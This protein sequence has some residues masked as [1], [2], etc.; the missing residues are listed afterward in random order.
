MRSSGLSS[1][2]RTSGLEWHPRSKSLTDRESWHTLAQATVPTACHRIVFVARSLRSNSC[3]LLAAVNR[4]AQRV[5]PALLALS[6][7]AACAGDEPAASDGHLRAR[8]AGPRDATTLAKW[9][10]VFVD[11]PGALASVWGTSE[12]DVWLAGSDAHDGLGPLVLHLSSGK[13]LRMR[14]GATGD[15]WWVH[16]FDDGSVFFVGSEGQIHRYA[17]GRFR[18]VESPRTRGTV[19]GVWGSGPNDVWAVGGDPI[20]G[21]GAFV[22]RYAGDHFESAGTLPVAPDDVIAYFKVWGTS[23][24]DVW[25]VGTPGIVLH[26]D[27]SRLER[28]D[29]GVFEPLFTVHAAGSAYAVVGGADLGVLLEKSAGAV[30][31]RAPLPDGTGLLTGVWL[32]GASGYAVGAQGTVLTRTRAGW[33]DAKT[34]ISTT[35][36]LHSVWIDPTGDVWTVGGDVLFPPYGSGMLI[37]RGAGL[38]TTYTAEPESFDGGDGSAVATR[39]H[40]DADVDSRVDEA[41]V[42]AEAGPDVADVGPPDAAPDGDAA[43][44]GADAR[45]EVRFVRCGGSTCALPAERCCAA[46]GTGVPIGCVASS[47]PCPSGQAPVSCDEPADCAAGQSCCLN[48]YLQAGDL[49]NV[50]CESSCKGPSVCQTNSDCGGA[51]CSTFSIM[52]SYM[53]CPPPAPAP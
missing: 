2:G 50:Q 16:G 24:N 29:P 46:A 32:T 43:R 39:D 38:P 6:V 13:W 44:D 33:I 15:L 11:L 18:R 52:K 37:H 42:G 27:G 12:K 41:S 23:A 8:D 40:V 7:T 31:S 20:Y 35:K 4:L 36:A 17:H 53:T 22:W 21:T 30:W 28:V 48:R 19:Y 3:T 25:I 26:Y 9:K 10:S 51:T 1:T 14:T 5:L 34:G 47:T 49:V 45:A